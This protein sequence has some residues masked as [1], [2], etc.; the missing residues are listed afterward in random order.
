MQVVFVRSFSE[1]QRSLLLRECVAVIYTPANEHF[2]IVPVEGQSAC[3]DTLCIYHPPAP[4]LTA[5]ALLSSPLPAFVSV[6]PPGALSEAKRV[7]PCTASG[8]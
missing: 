4:P 8:L 7:Q 3:I 5:F 6:S 1:A 2:G